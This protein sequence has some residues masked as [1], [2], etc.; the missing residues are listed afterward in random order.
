MSA[1]PLRI[2]EQIVE[3]ALAA[4]ELPERASAEV[5]ERA[6]A[7]LLERT[8]AELLARVAVA[9]PEQAFAELPE[10][11]SSWPLRAVEGGVEVVLQAVGLASRGQVP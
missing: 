10:W 5:L 7:E 3:A 2:L 8:S 11:A 1:G 4:V 6:S 9:L